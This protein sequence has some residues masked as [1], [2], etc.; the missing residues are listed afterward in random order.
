MTPHFKPIQSRQMMLARQA[1]FVINGH[2]QL[3]EVPWQ[4]EIVR[5]ENVIR[6]RK[7]TRA[8]DKIL[9]ASDWSFVTRPPCT[10]S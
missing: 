4:Y 7:A 1:R 9:L 6:T 10:G 3:V 5:F 8:A 2:A